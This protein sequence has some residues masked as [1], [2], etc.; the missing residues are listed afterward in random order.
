MRPM[1]PPE[2]RKQSLIKGRRGAGHDQELQAGASR[3]TG[4]LPGLPWCIQAGKRGLLM[5][6]VALLAM[7]AA[8]C[9][10]YQQDDFSEEYFVETYLIAGEPL[11][12]IRLSTTAPLESTWRFDEQAVDDAQ[13][14]IHRLN[15]DSTRIESFAYNRTQ[16]G[17][18]E[19]VDLDTGSRPRVEPLA[20][21]ELHI[22]L[23]GRQQ[24]MTAHTT[25]PDTFRVVRA[26]RDTAAY[27]SADRISIDYSL[28]S[29]PGRQNIYLF[30]TEALEPEQYP[31]T[32]FWQQTVEEDDEQ[33]EQQARKVRSN[34]IN[35]DNYE[36]DPV[37]Q[38][39]T[40]TY[41]WIGVAYFGPN[42]ITAYAI[43]TNVFDYYRSQEVQGGGGGSVSPGE[44]PSV[45]YN[46]EGGKG[47]FGSMAGASA[48]V[49][50]EQPEPG[51]NR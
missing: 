17:V 24:D 8:S 38:T 20:I 13:V 49:Y 23:P 37:D 48:E 2:N 19:P 14:T 22:D 21:Y 25:V 3:M 16:S 30:S 39:I 31:L 29:Y 32:P 11:P 51:E 47:L 36:V 15:Q 44:I 42:R 4:G 12:Q 10:L 40:L 45:L 26:N 18:Y 34:L 27:Q 5:G 50:I 46:I 1:T 6:A 7:T 33:G 9:D 35:Q 43:D 28:S 41:P